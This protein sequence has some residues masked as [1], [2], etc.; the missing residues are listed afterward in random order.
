MLIR[1]QEANQA[2]RKGWD[3]KEVL[4]KIMEGKRSSG[5][6]STDYVQYSEI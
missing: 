5:G 4:K 1:E 3:L 2:S 6:K